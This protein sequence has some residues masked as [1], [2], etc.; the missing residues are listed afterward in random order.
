MAHVLK[1]RNRASERGAEVIEFAIILPL[2]LLIVFGII[3]FGFLFQRYVVVTNAAME[4]ARVRVLPGYL[5]ADA[6]ARARSYAVDG[7]VPNAGACPPYCV[8]VTQTTVPNGTGGTW[9]AFQVDVAYDHDYSY[10][11]PIAQLFGGNFTSVTLRARSTM[12]S[13]VAPAGGGS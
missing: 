1:S 7:G 11:G 12:R 3:D 9:P 2:L 8:T 5:D 13:Q 4:G 10:I 6:I